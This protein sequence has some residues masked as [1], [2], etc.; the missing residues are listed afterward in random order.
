MAQTRKGAEFWSKIVAE[1][2]SSGGTR[3]AVAARHGISVA[4]LNYHLH[5]ARRNGPGSEQSAPA[6]MLPVR[7]TATRSRHSIELE[8]SDG[9]RLRFPEGCDPAYVAELVARVR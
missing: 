9:V 4:A 3:A 7:V 1:A 6:V 2:T 5:K 8:L